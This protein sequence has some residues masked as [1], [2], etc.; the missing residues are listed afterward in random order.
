VS[1]RYRAQ[2][3]LLRGL[4]PHLFK[5]EDPNS[6]LREAISAGLQPADE[7]LAQGLLAPRAPEAIAHLQRAL[8]LDRREQH[9]Y[10]PLLELL[11]VMGNLDEAKETLRVWTIL[12]PDDPIQRFYAAL[13]ELLDGKEPRFDTPKNE[14]DSFPAEYLA[15]LRSI[16]E[17][18]KEIRRL[19]AQPTLIEAL[20]VDKN[21]DIR[22][23]IL[24]QRIGQACEALRAMPNDYGAHM[25]LSKWSLELQAQYKPAMAAAE[26]EKYDEAI[27]HLDRLLENWPVGVFYLFRG[28]MAHQAGRWEDGDRDLMMAAQVP[29]GFGL[30]VRRPAAEHAR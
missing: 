14:T 19:V 1:Q 7:A 2:I 29:S 25:P 28:I 16:A 18:V 4:L 22:I 10:P 30:D 23:F 17:E 26:A 3:L 11:I 12:Y 15:P 6:L 8:Q 27:P 24:V 5:T 13:I 9:A 21:D 20:S